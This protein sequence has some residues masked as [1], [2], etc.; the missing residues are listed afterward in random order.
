M[1]QAVRRGWA[2]L[3]AATVGVSIYTFVPAGPVVEMLYT[4]AGFPGAAAALQVLAVA[5][6]FRYLNTMVV[7]VLQTMDR[8]A[9]WAKAGG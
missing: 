7:M 5:L 2:L 4:Q 6:G 9:Q 8:Q 3:F 1:R